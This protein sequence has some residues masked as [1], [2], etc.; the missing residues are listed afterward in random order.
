RGRGKWLLREAFGHLLPREVFTRRKMGF[1]VP[2]DSWFRGELKSVTADLLLSPTAHCLAFFRPEAIEALW[3]AH[4]SHQ[5]DH[6]S[7][8]WALVML[9]SWLREWAGPASQLQ[10][11]NSQ[12]QSLELQP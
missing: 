1:G 11:S 8:L 10:V 3:D 6:A 2:L 7:R 12:V 4:Q 9:E 5:Y